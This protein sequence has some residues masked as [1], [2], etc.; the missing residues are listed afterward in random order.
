[1]RRIVAGG[2]TVLLVVLAWI[3][4]D[5]A[6][7]VPAERPRTRHLNADGTPRY[8]N[9][10]ARE[11]SPYLRQHAHNP[12]DWYPWGEEAFAKARAERKPILLSVGYSTCH[13]CHVMEEE[14]FEDEEIAAYLNAHY[15]A[16]KVDREERPDVDRVY[17]NAVQLMSDGGGGWPMTVWLTPERRPFYAG[18]YYPPRAGVRGLR[19]GF[20]ELSTRLA[21]VYGQDPA[22][23]ET[24]A[25]D[26]VRR[27]EAAATASAQVSRPGVDALTRAWAEIAPT[28]DGEHGGFG[29]PPKFPR[30]SQLL[31]LLRYHRRTGD[32]AA[33][34]QVVR[35]LDAMAAGGIHDQVGGGFHRYSVDAAW[36]VPHFEKMLYDNALLAIAYLEAS[37]AA[38]RADLAAVARTTLE[39]LVRDMQA[40]DGGFFAASDADSEGEEG[41]YF[42]WTASQLADVLGPERGRV[43]AQYF[44]VGDGAITLATPHPDRAPPDLDDVR[45]ALRDAR[46]RRVAP[47]VDRKVIVSWNGLAIAAF[48]RAAR[49]L[50]DRRL[51]NVARTTAKAI[52]DARRDGRL[53]RYLI[54]G[55]AHGDA[56]LDDYAFLIAGLLDLFE[57]TFD[58]TWLR[59]ALALQAVQD[60]RF[61]DPRGGYFQTAD[62]QETLLT[63][64][65][66][67][68]DGAE[69]AGNSVALENL[70]R[71]QE[72]TMN[73]RH[74]E[75]AEALL[76][77]FGSTITRHPSALP[78]MLCGLDALA[79]PMKE[80][81]LV[82]PSDTK[83]LAPFLGQLAHT[84][85]PNHVLAV[86]LGG[87]PD[88]ALVAAIPVTADKTTIDGKATVYVCERH[89]CKRPTTDPTAFAEQLAR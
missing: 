49:A 43:A 13:W 3:V 72:L 48:A 54:D 29:G 65:K 63:R 37:R 47:H 88:A 55:S 74:R 70:V 89:V 4:W 18:T 86:A 1:M 59:E 21:E 19:I 40:R 15:V 27:L 17:M 68:Y 85:L 38:G 67:D 66:P 60:A 9:R 73:D 39:Y 23:V 20:L 62:D 34:D 87:A 7:E 10:L 78:H 76:A 51:A 35:T 84:Y 80:I 79:G 14:S 83:A 5:P 26:V 61:A 25:A 44:D 33:L 42:T 64:E 75:R 46:G 30:P 69:P 32:A 2:L 16:I 52:L 56:Y 28:F 81:V 12:V 71:L 11:R 24:A 50:A 31:V 58:V 36:R 6:R 45:R 53:P 41:K 57:A 77:A 82:S 22:R 8:T